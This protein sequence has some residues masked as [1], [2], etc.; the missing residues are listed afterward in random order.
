MYVKVAKYCYNG[1]IKEATKISVLVMLW[2]I[3]NAEYFLRGKK[4]NFSENG[5]VEDQEGKEVH[6]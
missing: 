4:K 2:G 3:R 5:H 1:K 6:P